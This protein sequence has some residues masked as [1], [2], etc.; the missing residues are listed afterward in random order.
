MKRLL[1]ATT[2]AALV[3]LIAFTGCGAAGSKAVHQE[4]AVST[5]LT[6]VSAPARPSPSHPVSP[7]PSPQP[8]SAPHHQ[9]VIIAGDSIPE[10]LGPMITHTLDGPLFAGHTESHPITGLV[11]DDYFDWPAEAHKIAA[12]HPDTVIMLIGGNDDQPIT[13]SSGTH[14]QPASAEWDT[15]YARRAGL[16][17]DALRNGGVHRVYWLTMPTTDLQGMNGA[18]AAMGQAIRAAAKDRPGVTV[19]DTDVLLGANAGTPVAHQ[20]DGIH[21]STLGSQM[22]SNAL[23]GRLR[24]DGGTA[25]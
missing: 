16:V 10:D 21:L 20:P 23:I 3:G 22:V 7:S 18:V 12:E 19:Y 15:E 5:P 1:P 17:M 13:L 8:V 4:R 6:H 14:L 2:L 24:V 25:A 11:R 9:S